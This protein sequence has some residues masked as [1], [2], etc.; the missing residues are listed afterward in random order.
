MKRFSLLRGCLQFYNCSTLFGMKRGE[1]VPPDVCKEIIRACRTA[2]KSA[3]AAR[4]GISRNTLNNLLKRKQ[5]TGSFSTAARGRKP[6]LGPDDLPVLKQLA[7]AHPTLSW[8][9]LREELSSLLKRKIA[10]N[11]LHL[12]LKNSTYLREL[13]T[14]RELRIKQQ[15]PLL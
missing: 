1:T 3:V 9:Q 15:L 11:S 6:S 12:A 2:T 7:L 5:T 10:K 14:K 4:F 8:K 13:C